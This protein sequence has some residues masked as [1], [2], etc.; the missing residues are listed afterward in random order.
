MGRR[1]KKMDHL[2]YNNPVNVHFI[3][4]GGSSMSGLASILISRGF[5]VSG[6]DAVHNAATKE[7]EE[8]G[9]RIGYPQS[10][11]NIPEDTDLVVYTAAIHDD[12]PELSEARRRGIPTETR[13]VLLGQ[14]M[15]QYGQSVNVSGT[16]GKT[17]TTSIITDILISAG[18][19]PTVSV[20]GVVESFGSNMRIGSSDV[21]VTEACE[22]TNSFLHSYPTI[23]V[24]LNIEEDHLDFFKDIDDIR[25]SFKAFADL[26]PENG[27][28]VINS[29]IEGFEDFRPESGASFITYGTDPDKSDYLAD[30][31]SFD[32][33]G[34][35]SYDL[36][37]R[38]EKVCRVELSIPG[39]H[40]V[41]NSLAAIAACMAA[42]ATAEDVAKGLKKSTGAHRRLEYKGEFNGVSVIDDYAHHPDEI[43]AT[44]DAVRLM[45][46]GDVWGVFQPHTYSRTR[47]FLDEFVDAL[48][49]GASH[50]LLAEVYNDREI[51]TYGVS[52]ADIARKVREKG[53]DGIF[54][55]TFEEI[56]DYLRKNCKPGD[57]VVTLGSKDVYKIA[58]ELTK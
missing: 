11:D 15:K 33:K 25:K 3:G 43:K 57:V 49:G 41:S 7:L 35:G 1:R 21:F 2:D 46:K 20:G 22:Y 23:A 14:I 54:F 30:N 19:D 31:V 37:I 44:L 13:A 47:D 45:C 39:M 42:G 17:T 8:K 38:G 36:L 32:E 16:H 58:D 5:K 12:D 40:N 52:S 27:T 29:D 48:S 53:G 26:L 9:V 6:S 10:P 51:D 50:S 56:T 18:M 24:I 28:L 4:I 55:D 34:M